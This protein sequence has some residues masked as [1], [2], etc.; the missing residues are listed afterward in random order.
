MKN[1]LLFV[2]VILMP[3]LSLADQEIYYGGQLDV[4]NGQ[5]K[6]QPTI[7]FYSKISYDQK[8]ETI[9]MVGYVIGNPA[10]KNETHVTKTD[11]VRDSKGQ[12]WI[13]LSAKP[14]ARREKVDVIFKDKKLASISTNIKDKN[15]GS[16]KFFVKL[17]EKVLGETSLFNPQGKVV[18][19]FKA[20]ANYL[21]AKAFNDKVSKLKVVNTIQ[22]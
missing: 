18:K 1:Y 16:F 6:K 8:K 20:S 19:Q 12:W 17:D 4:Y 15:R 10:K 21:D 9:K 3:L 14:P 7:D 11:Y 22:F 5:G 13:N 2:A